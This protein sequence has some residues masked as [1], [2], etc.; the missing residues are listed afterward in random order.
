M[1]GKQIELL[2][3]SYQVVKP[4]STQ[5]SRLFYQRLFELQPSLRRL[6][7]GD[8]TEHGKLMQI[9]V[10]VGA[11]RRLDSIL[12]A[13]AK[14][15]L[16]RAGVRDELQATVATALLW[17]LEQVLGKAFTSDVRAGWMTVY[18]TVSAV[19]RHRAPSASAA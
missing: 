12:P 17:T 11:L 16:R 1:T 15:V 14:T 2:Q 18:E 3:E 19:I 6:F 5:A 13:V 9:G 10:A 8:R 7:R 4:I